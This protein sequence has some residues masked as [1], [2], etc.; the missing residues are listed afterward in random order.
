VLEKARMGEGLREGAVDAVAVEEWLP[1]ELVQAGQGRVMVPLHKLWADHPADLVAASRDLGE[2]RP[3]D[4]RRVAAAT[5]RAARDLS[6]GRFDAV[7]PAATGAAGSSETWRGAL[8]TARPGFDPFPFLSGMRVILE[9]MKKRGQT[10]LNLDFKAIATE[11]C[12]TDLTRTLMQEVGFEEVPATDSRDERMIGC[13]YT[14][15]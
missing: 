15:F 2:N 3:D 12:L 14:F 10:P 7:A 4:L 11:T 9:E 8:E 1:A 6:K 5:L 13:C